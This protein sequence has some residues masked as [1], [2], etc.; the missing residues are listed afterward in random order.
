M[1]NMR[2][3]TAFLLETCILP[4]PPRRARVPPKFGALDIDRARAILSAVAHLHAS[5]WPSPTAAT[6]PPPPAAAT[7]PVSKQGLQY[8][9]QQQRTSLTPAVNCRQHRG[10]AGGGGG[11]GGDGRGRY[12]DGLHEQG[13][14]WS[15]EKRDPGDLAGLEQEYQKLFLAFRPLLPATWFDDA[16][17]S[18][19]EAAKGCHGADGKVG[20]GSH[21]LSED[22]HQPSGESGE[23]KGG[24][25]PLLG[26]RLA[27]RA[28]ELDGAAHATR[29]GGTLA[30]P[31]GGEE[32]AAAA[33]G[34]RRGVH[35]G[36]G[37]GGRGRTLVHGDLKTWNVFFK[38]GSWRGAGAE[39]AGGGGVGN[40]GGGGGAPM[41]AAGG[42]VKIIDWQ[43]HFIGDSVGVRTFFLLDY[44]HAASMKQTSTR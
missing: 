11:S 33:A 41:D 1:L 15:L 6:P 37:G 12:A 22:H 36:Q 28:V 31:S 7:P 25:E 5:F 24:R 10:E 18:Q 42:R 29:A 8:Q 2:V 23:S 27:A 30:P 35:S 19:Q 9:Q 3:S 14:F 32:P 43:V 26:H 21:G 17:P 39:G 38:R 44:L 4:R 34:G 40:G 16:L 13:T 20:K